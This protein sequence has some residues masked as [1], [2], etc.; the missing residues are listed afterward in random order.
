MDQTKTALL[1]GATGL[2]GEKLLG[3][4][5]EDQRYDKVYVVN[6]RSKKYTSSKIVESV[7]DFADLK[8]HQHLFEADHVFI[9]LGTTIKKAGSQEAF[10][11]VDY[12]LQL[13]I[14][15]LAKAKKVSQLVYVSALGANA[16]SSNF[17]MRTKARL[18][19]AIEREGPKGS[20]VVRPSMLFGN[21]KEKRLGESI[22]IFLMKNLEFLMIG[23][24]KK[25]RGIYDA[26][27]AEAMIFIA[28]STPKQKAFDSDELKAISTSN[29]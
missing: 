6:R 14:A 16:S 15:K 9:S 25:Y 23:A 8:E 24:F 28:N 17:Y 12:E 19:D 18:E 26:D 21:R 20:Y 22:G 4:L 1:F 5:D 29:F 27:V 13:Q 2:V 7:I 3:F 10:E 11:K